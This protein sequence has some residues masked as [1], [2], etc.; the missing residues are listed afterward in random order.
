MAAPSSDAP[1]LGGAA[2]DK[3]SKATIAWYSI[4]S[5]PIFGAGMVTS[6]LLSKFYVDEMGADLT[7]M[8]IATFLAGVVASYGQLIVGYVSDRTRTRL[9][10]RLPYLAV[11]GPL[12]GVSLFF[13]LSPIGVSGRAASVWFLVWFCVYSAAN[14]IVSVA[15]GALGVEMTLDDASRTQ[16]FGASI[17]LGTFGLLLVAG[18]NPVLRGFLSAAGTMRVLGVFLGGG[19]LLSLWAIV[20]KVRENPSAF[21][22]TALPLIP[23][24][25]S[26]AQN[27]P[28]IIYM[29][30]GAILSL[31]NEVTGM[32]AFVLQY[33]LHVDP[34]KYFAIA[35]GVYATC[36]LIGVPL[37]TWLAQRYGKLRIYRLSMILIVVYG[38]LCWLATLSASPWP[39]VASLGFYGAS[40]AGLNVLSSVI[41][42]DCVDYDELHT[43]KRRESTYG[44]LSNLPGKAASIAGRSVPLMVL[45][46]LDYHKDAEQNANVLFALRFFVSGFPAV[47]ALVAFLLFLRYPMTEEVHKAVVRAIRDRAAGR[48]VVDPL[49]GKPV[50]LTSIV[51]RVSAPGVDGTAPKVLAAALT[52]AVSA[53]ELGVGAGSAGDADAEGRIVLTPTEAKALEERQRAEDASPSMFLLYFSRRD[54]RMLAGQWRKRFLLKFAASVGLWTLHLALFT[55]AAAQL[56]TANLLN[57]AYLAVLGAAVASVVLSYEVARFKGV[58]WMTAQPKA[59]LAEYVGAFMRGVDAV[60]DARRKQAREG[61][62]AGPPRPSADA[63]MGAPAFGDDSSDEDGAAAPAVRFLTARVL[64]RFWTLHAVA[65]A[66]WVLLLWAPGSARA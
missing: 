15:R 18:L 38:V 52:D 48:A 49:T 61:G 55:V 10:R 37:M 46:L 42:S 45:G 11:G 23:G 40:L 14:D 9:G 20:A 6:A 65:A 4:S 32:F 59:R 43:G 53:E 1:L 19:A 22:R 47:L 39:F 34:N 58:R 21:K 16:L 26:C 63:E 54:L 60:R 31:M 13:L 64:A 5:V 24:Y 36:Q 62:A 12:F 35:A 3:L 66:C 8:S 41:Q 30:S 44:S 2:S 50:V 33:V 57:G 25:R 29:T 7:V 51:A 17:A 56:F 28:W 27:R